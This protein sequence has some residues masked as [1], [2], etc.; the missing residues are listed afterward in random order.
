LR[1]STKAAA[2]DPAA[3][4]HCALP[5]P[6]P[7]ARSI[8]PV[9][10]EGSTVAVTGAAGFVG[11]WVV[12]YLL[13]RGYGVRACVRD[14]D[15]RQK[16]GFLRAMPAFVAGTLTLHSC[17]MTTPGV[18][19]SVFD[20]CSAVIDTAANLGVPPE[21]MLEE[22]T[23]VNRLLIASVEKAASVRRVVFTSSDEAMLDA[24]LDLLKANPIVDEARF[25]DQSDPLCTPEILGYNI[26]KIAC[27]TAFS[28]AAL[29]SGGRWDCMHGNPGDIVGP[30]LSP[31]QASGG[32]QSAVGAMAMGIALPQHP[33]GRPFMTV[34]VRDVA[35]AHVLL[36]ES[37]TAPSGARYLLD[38]DDKVF[39]D[40]YGAHIAAALLPAGLH[41]DGAPSCRFP[42]TCISIF[43]LL[44]GGTCN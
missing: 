37:S 36:M 8:M 18:F 17:E 42:C 39:I 15:D 28:E 6:Q 35:M 25:T 23:L 9:P 14:A 21:Q 4:L 13:E 44:H 38:T 16:T 20:G 2:S 12:T 19:D 24:N 5:L 26:A 41:I 27:E 10:A 31:H 40:D 22:Y 3:A 32:F 34:D 30:I 7:L 29:A 33:L 43:N 1:Y 11:S